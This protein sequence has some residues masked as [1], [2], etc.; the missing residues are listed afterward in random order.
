MTNYDELYKKALDDG[1][2]VHLEPQ[3][4]KLEEGNII[5]GRFLGRDLC[6]TKKRKMPDY[7]LYNLETNT[8][9]V[10][11]PVS[12]AFDKGPGAKLEEGKI[13]ALEYIGMQKISG[14]RQ[15]KN[16]ECTEIPE[17]VADAVT[18]RSIE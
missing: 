16:I 9:A 2:L 5:I 14:G 7:Y 6:P 15:F 10:R 1:T 3:R 12:Q 4:V 18:N 8:G 13:Y 17:N 11:F